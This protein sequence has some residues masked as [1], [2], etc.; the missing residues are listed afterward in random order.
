MLPSRTFIVRFQQSEGVAVLENV[1]TG[2][3][4]RL[5]DLDALGAEVGR[6]LDSAG[7]GERK[8]PENGGPRDP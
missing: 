8:D 2:E 7:D 1:A 4:V 3:R 6:W 5:Q